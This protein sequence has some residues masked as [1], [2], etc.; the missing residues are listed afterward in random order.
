MLKFKFQR[1]SSRETPPRQS[2]IESPSEPKSK[3]PSKPPMHH[4]KP[5]RQA[6]RPRPPANKSPEEPSNIRF[7]LSKYM[8]RFLNMFRSTHPKS[9]SFLK[10]DGSQKKVVGQACLLIQKDQSTVKCFL[11]ICN[12][13]IITCS[14]ILIV[15]GVNFMEFFH[16]DKLENWSYN[17]I[18]APWYM[19]VLG[20]FT[21]S[22]G[23]VGFLLCIIQNGFREEI[24][25]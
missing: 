9:R 13:I 14:T 12:F 25:S 17:S 23:L 6:Q 15:Y 20:S 8:E 22:L 16:L 7:S 21:L 19:I 11:A 3:P 24:G 2:S 18:I 4:G 1:P 5:Q 10:Q